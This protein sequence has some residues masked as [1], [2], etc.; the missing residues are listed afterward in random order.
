MKNRLRKNTKSPETRTKSGPAPN[1]DVKVALWL[2]LVLFCFY[3]LTAPAHRPYGDEEEYLAV[4]EN[5]LVHGDLSV[6]RTQADAAGQLRNI[7]SYSKFSL[8]QSVLLLPFVTAGMVF[9]SITAGAELI[10]YMLPALESAAICLLLFLLIRNLG[11]A[12]PELVLSR[13]SALAIAA[14]TGLGTQLWPSA[15]VLFADQSAALL[16]TVAVYSLVRFTYEKSGQ[17]WATAAAWAAAWAVFCKPIFALACP[18]LMIYAIWITRKQPRRFNTR[19]TIWLVVTALLPFALVVVVQLWHNNL[20]FGSALA[21]GYEQGR[22]GEYGFATPLWVGLYGTLLSSGRSLF[23]YSPLCLLTFFGARDFFKRAP[24]EAAL[25]AG[26]SLPLLLGYAKWW[27]W[28]GGWEWGTRFYIFLI[29]LLMWLSVPAWRWLDL[30]APA[31]TMHRVQQFLLADLFM[32]AVYVQLLG[33]LIF[34]LSYWVLIANEVKVFE[35]QVYQKG[36][37]DIR[38]D[39]VLAHF[40]PEFSPLAGHAW[41]I[42]ATW[43]QQKFDDKALSLSAPWVALNAKWAPQNVRPYLGYDL[44]F[45]GTRDSRVRSDG[46][47]GEILWSLV[48][49][50]GIALSVARLKSFAQAKLSH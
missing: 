32:G 36:I 42:W 13:R 23:L 11:N 20:R 40:V 2:G 14:M 24:A 34:P 37:W 43:N 12:S 5:V 26:V 47:A 8:G 35:R 38:D 15:R 19:Q 49:L 50:G 41:L 17:R 21:L 31:T 39:M 44:W 7:A 28:H 33:V 25:V 30:T 4:A 3:V 10:I 16:L 29:P 46:A 48:L 6:T 45:L 18:A 22:D 27:S 9:S 1:P